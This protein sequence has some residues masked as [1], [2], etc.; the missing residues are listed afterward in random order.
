[1]AA[2]KDLRQFIDRVEALGELK[3]VLGADWN[4]EI[5]GITEYA[6]H[7]RNGPAVLFDEIRDYP[8]GHRVFINGMGSANRSALAL[9]LPTGNG[10]KELLPM[11]KKEAGKIK[12][13][14]PKFV[15]D[16]P[17]LENVKRGDQVDMLSFPTPLW[18]ELDG[19][20]YLGTGCA[21]I[22]RDP[23]TDWVN[24]GTYR[25]MLKDSKRLGLYISPGKHGRIMREKY[26]SRGQKMPVAM[27]FGHDPSIFLASSVELPYGLCEYDYVGGI[28]GEAV[29]VIRGPVTGLP[30]PATGELVVEGFIEPDEVDEEGPFGEW[31]GYYGSG[32]RKEPM[33]RVEAVYYRNNPIILGSPPGKPPA[34]LTAYR[35]LMRSALIWEQV[36]GAGVP[37]VSG[38]WAHEVGGSRLL[39]AIGIHTRYNGHARQAAHA[40]MSCHAGAYAGRLIVVVDDDIDVTS[41]DD[42]MWAV[43]TRCDPA[44]DLDLVKKSWST[45][46]DP[47][48]TP[49]QRER[50]DFTNS[51]L[52]I[53]ATRPFEWRS[54]FPPVAEMS[55]EMRERIEREWG[56]FLLSPGNAKKTASGKRVPAGV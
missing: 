49:E 1:M 25:V 20:R 38:V 8:A 45:P 16:G 31:T 55:A 43:C 53:D 40:A 2:H 4:L 29:E 23:D 13:I 33:M 39:V 46:L 17:L 24:L 12:P 27:S 28:K 26:F 5:G 7:R 52:I 50:K 6:Q 48:V 3:T 14:P 18:H 44:E 22:I 42:V 35:S 56:E 51:R 21:I 19:G 32:Q 15:N 10:Y 34:E 11:W 47:R 9:G 37:D 41:L 36:E 54:E 30:L